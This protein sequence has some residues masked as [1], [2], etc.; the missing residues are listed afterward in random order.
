MSDKK[1][2]T[3]IQ[4]CR[5]EIFKQGLRVARATHQASPIFSSLSTPPSSFLASTNC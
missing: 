3:P 1:T 5:R 2:K 4:F